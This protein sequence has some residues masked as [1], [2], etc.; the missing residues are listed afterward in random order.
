MTTIQG[1]LLFKSGYYYQLLT[2]LCG[3]YSRVATITSCLPVCVATIQGWLLLPTAYCSVWLL[4]KVTSCLPVCVATIQGWLLLPTAYCSVWL[5]FKVTSCLLLCVATIQGWLLLHIPAAYHSVW[6]LFKDG[7]YSVPIIT[8]C[9]LLCEATIQHGTQNYRCTVACFE[10]RELF[11]GPYCTPAAYRS[12]WLLF[13][14]GYYYQL[15]TALCRYYSRAATITSC[16]P[17]CVSTI[18][19]RLLVHVSAAYHSVCLLFKSGY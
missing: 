17:L 11:G 16:L 6:L 19:E 2:Y 12:V 1:W 18:Q 15:L 5:L 9:L 7:Y 14:S 8:S 13:K 3:C 10:K 4:F